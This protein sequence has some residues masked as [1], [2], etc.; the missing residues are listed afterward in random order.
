[1]SNTCRPI[2]PGRCISGI[3]GGRWWGMRWRICWGGPGLT[4]AD[5]SLWLDLVQEFTVAR[6]N[7]SIRDD[8]AALGVHFDVFSSERALIASGAV[9]ATIAQLDRQG[10]IYE[11][12]LEP[13]KGKLPDDWEPRQQTL[14]RAT[15][16]GDDV[17]RPLRKSDGSN[18]YFANDI[19]YHFEKAQRGFAVMID[20]WGADHGGYV[21]RMQA[22]VKALGDATLD[23]VLCQI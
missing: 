11:G 6:M 7:E 22:A 23:V 16:F 10:L 17:D 8:L 19:A 4:V 20:V 21:K 13:P 9:D 14:F 3:A 12:T 5:P 2:R 18:T 15:R 1:M